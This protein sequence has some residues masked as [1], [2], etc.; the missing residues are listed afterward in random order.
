MDKSIHTDEYETLVDLLKEAREAAE[1]T[2]EELA[3]KLKQSQ[4]F[5]S[6]METGDRRLDL[7]QLR[8]VCAVLGITL[9]DFV[10]RFEERVAEKA[11]PVGGTAGGTAGGRGRRGRSRGRR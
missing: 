2:Q 8:T 9:T 3:A 10:A 6:K 4:S 5:V 1:L 11:K 7:V